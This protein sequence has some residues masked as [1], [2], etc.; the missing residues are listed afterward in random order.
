MAVVDVRDF[1]FDGGRIK[2]S[3]YA[4]W[5]SLN[6]DTSSFLDVSRSLRHSGAA[7]TRDALVAD[8]AAMDGLVDALQGK[9]AEVSTA[10]SARSVGRLPLQP[11]QTACHH[12]PRSIRGSW[13][14]GKGGSREAQRCH[15]MP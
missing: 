3:M 2:G 8:P 12:H 7:E 11:T 1:D 6:G 9:N 5:W 4:P 14:C 10:R 13:C 15:C